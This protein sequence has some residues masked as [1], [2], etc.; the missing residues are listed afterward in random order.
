MNK[1][2]CS[3]TGCNRPVHARH[4]C[5]IHYRRF[6]RTGD[7]LKCHKYEGELCSVPTCTRPA[8]KRGWC[9]MHYHRWQRH[10]DPSVV[11]DY[12]TRSVERRFWDH[13]APGSNG[14]W[15]WTGAVCAGYG[16][17]IDNT[18]HRYAYQFARGEIP[19]GLQLD[20]L[21]RNQLCVNPFHLE[22]VTSLVNNQRRTRDNNQEE[23]SKQQHGTDQP[24][25]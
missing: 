14:C 13:V 23:T 4:M 10:G 5:Q 2:P 8:R 12:F 9:S 6:T 20:H 16:Y 17:F 3:I 22:P 7:P 18:A 21:C 25:H 1:K 11:S 24:K 19:N 15:I